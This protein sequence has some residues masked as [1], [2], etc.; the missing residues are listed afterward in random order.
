MLTENNRLLTF[1]WLTRQ[2]T[3]AALLAG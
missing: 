1:F 3:H 2:L